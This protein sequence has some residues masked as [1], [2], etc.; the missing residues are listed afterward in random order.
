M[1]LYWTNFARTGN[2]NGAGLP[3]WPRYDRKRM[4]LHLD[5]KIAVTPDTSRSQ[6]EFLQSESSH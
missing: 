3:Q 6:F 1:I 5:S 2:P 4:L